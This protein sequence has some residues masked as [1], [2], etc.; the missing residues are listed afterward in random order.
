MIDEVQLKHFGSVLRAKREAFAENYAYFAPQLSPRFNCFDFIQ[1]DEMRLS[2]I[3]AM[4]LNP[5][6]NH[7]QGELFLKL[8]FA[9]IDINYPDEVSNIKRNEIKVVC[10]VSTDR[11]ENTQRRIDILVSFGNSFGDSYGLAIE[12]KPW[13]NDQNQQLSDYA[14]QM[15]KKFGDNWCLVYLSGDNSDPSE[16]SATADQIT[17]WKSNGQYRKISFA[18]VVEWLKKC[19]AQCQSDH[20][21]HFLRDFIGY[22]QRT[23]LGVRNMMDAKLIQDFILK[24]ENLSLAL[25]IEQQ[26]SAVKNELLQK[27]LKDFKVGLEAVDSSWIVRQTKKDFGYNSSQYQGLVFFKPEWKKYLLK[28]SFERNQCG[29][30]IFG[31]CKRDDKNP[32]L[33]PSTVN[34]LNRKLSESGKSSRWWPWYCGVYPSGNKEFFLGISSEETTKELVEKIQ[35]LKKASEKIIDEAEAR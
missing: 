15:Q 32:N 2:K 5:K 22:C 25:A 29:L 12:N 28:I 33:P 27:F 23:F 20:V 4:L 24:D 30:L 14:K 31:I 17:D 26:M 3:L 35:K 34:D 11:I 13:A 1:P 9:A 7:A 10:E 8:F 19:E 16:Q 21:R 6:E 18:L